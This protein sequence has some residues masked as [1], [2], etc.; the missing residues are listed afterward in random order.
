MRDPYRVLGVSKSAS[1]D[2]IRGR[3]MKLRQKHNPCNFM[4]MR[5]KDRH[6]ILYDELEAAYNELMTSVSFRT[7]M[8]MYN[9]FYSVF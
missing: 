4:D 7:R 1:E 3:Y 2:K 6:R 9:R 8:N 5:E